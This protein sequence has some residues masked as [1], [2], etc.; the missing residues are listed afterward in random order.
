MCYSCQ[1]YWWCLIGNKASSL[2]ETLQAWHATF[3][4]LGIGNVLAATQ[5]RT[6]YVRW[7]WA[8]PVCLTGFHWYTNT[9][10]IWQR[11]TE[12]KR[13]PVNHECFSPPCRSNH[14]SA[15]GVGTKPDLAFHLSQ[16]QTLFYARSYLARGGGTLHGPTSTCA[17]VVRVIAFFPSRAPRELQEAANRSLETQTAPAVDSFGLAEPAR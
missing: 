17:H 1:K 14:L 8:I 13:P 5:T 11:G 7:D 4:Q 10:S 3:L 16:G 15:G 2:T 12:R 9:P 6:I